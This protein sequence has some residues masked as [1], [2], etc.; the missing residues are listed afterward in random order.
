M[1]SLRLLGLRH[2]GE[3]RGLREEEVALLD[4]VLAELACCFVI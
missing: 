1:S 2:A 4:E 3:G